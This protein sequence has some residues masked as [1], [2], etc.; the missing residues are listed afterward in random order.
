M[1]VC[2]TVAL[3][4]LAVPAIFTNPG[5]RNGTAHLAAAPAAQ[6]TNLVLDPIAAAFRGPLRCLR[7]TFAPGDATYVRAESG[8]GRGCLRFP[9]STTA[10]LHEVGG[11]WR[12]VLD[13]SSYSCPVQSL[14]AVVETELGVC[15]RTHAASHRKPAAMENS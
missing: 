9:P 6:A 5:R 13:T 2:V 3:A 7:L 12:S 11:E 14:P 8:H 1:A 10:I 15:P 4:A